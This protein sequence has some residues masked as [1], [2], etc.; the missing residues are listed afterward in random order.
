[1]KSRPGALKRKQKLDNEERERFGKNLAQLQ[2][3]RQDGDEGGVTVKSGGAVAT[4]TQDRWAALR[5][6]IGETLER[7]PDVV[8]GKG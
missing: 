2:Q 1:M 5:G 7:R 3:Q 6:F 8:V 4:A